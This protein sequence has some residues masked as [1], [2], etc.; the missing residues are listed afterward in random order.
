M[1][2]F[3]QMSRKVVRLAQPLVP[4]ASCGVTILGYHLIGAGTSSVVDLPLDAFRSQLSEL[5]DLAEVCRLDEALTYLESGLDN[6]RPLVVL[7]F[8]DAFD[9]FR[10]QA[11]PLL[12]A[13][14]MPSTLY[15]PVGFIEGARGTP[16]NGVAGAKP[17][18]WSA[19]REMAG[20]PLLTIGSHSWHHQDL[21]R[22]NVDLLRS[23]LRDSRS[24]LQQRLG[25]KIEHFCYPQA[26]WSA[27]V[28]QEVRVVYRSAVVAGG[29]RNV[30]GR[31]NPLRLSRIPIR[32]DMPVELT[33][34]VQSRLCL[35]EWAASCLRGLTLHPGAPGSD[36]VAR[37]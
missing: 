33:P 30:A 37:R 16:L 9:N 12:K 25:L 36:R 32:R 17:I 2:W 29:R 15:V 34:L 14:K 10:V 1:N 27:A 23:D 5:R 4:R 3:G 24:R 7:T 20:D 13:M 11:W 28:K 19:L 22:L 18:E 35:E 26:K 8:D 6:P 21:R 31:F